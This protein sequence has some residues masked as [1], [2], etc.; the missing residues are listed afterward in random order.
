MFGELIQGKSAKEVYDTYF[1]V[2]SD[3]KTATSGSGS[4]PASDSSDTAPMILMNGIDEMLS[5]LCVGALIAESFMKNHAAL[6][7]GKMCCP[8]HFKLYNFRKDDTTE[9]HYGAQT[10]DQVVER[11]A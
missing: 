1:P 11:R 7:L 8:P 4:G 2:D 6:G 9:P 3:H 5:Q 10:L